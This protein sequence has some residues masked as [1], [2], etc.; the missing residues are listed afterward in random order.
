ML[1]NVVSSKRPVKRCQYETIR[2]KEFAKMKNLEP[3][4]ILSPFRRP[5]CWQQ[6]KGVRDAS[7]NL[8]HYV[9]RSKMKLEYLI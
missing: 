7:N 4:I 2:Q 5:L 8:E 3:I 1:C 6:D 9:Y